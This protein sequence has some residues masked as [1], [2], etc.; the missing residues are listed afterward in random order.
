[1]CVLVY[2]GPEAAG[3]S[4]ELVPELVDAA[5]QARPLAVEESRVVK[6]ADGTERRVLKLALRGV[7]HGAYQLRVRYAGASGPLTSPAQA[8]R[9][10]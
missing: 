1:V 2:R 7:E 3:A 6:D 4:P 8:V 9:V 10:E 5:G